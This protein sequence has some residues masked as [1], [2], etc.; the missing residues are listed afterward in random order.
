MQANIYMYN[1]YHSYFQYFGMEYVDG[2]I[3]SETNVVLRLNG[4]D[5]EDSTGCAPKWSISH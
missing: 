3:L 1:Y 2:P 4:I 5:F